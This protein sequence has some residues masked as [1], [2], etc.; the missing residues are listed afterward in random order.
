MGA[1]HIHMEPDFLGEHGGRLAMAFGAGWAACFALCTALG[2]FLWNILG[3]AKD[4]TI[5]DLKATIASNEERCEARD[6]AQQT[7][8]LQ[9]ETMLWMH[10]PQALRAEIQAVVS[11]QHLEMRRAIESGALSRAENGHVTQR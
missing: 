10:G 3:K 4:D 5:A 11:E 7:R 2:A 9:L 8:I 1:A 6:T